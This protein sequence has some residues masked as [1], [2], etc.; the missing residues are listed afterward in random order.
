MEKPY[1]CI[2]TFRGFCKVLTQK[3]LYLQIG[4][5][6]RIEICYVV[7]LGHCPHTASLGSKLVVG[8]EFVTKQFYTFE[9]SIFLNIYHSV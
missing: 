6:L 2:V 7:S 9:T 1:K 5:C 4:K 3:F 8:S